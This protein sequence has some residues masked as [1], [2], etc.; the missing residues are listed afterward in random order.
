[1]LGINPLPSPLLIIR[2]FSWFGVGQSGV[3]SEIRGIPSN[4]Q[5]SPKNQVGFKSGLAA[6]T[7]FFDQN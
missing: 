3:S 2:S 7:T 5:V 1:M 4:F 6:G